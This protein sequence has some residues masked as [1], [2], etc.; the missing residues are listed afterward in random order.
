MLD[1]VSFTAKP[2]QT[3]AILGATGSGK[4]SLVQ[5]L[6][7]L[8]VRTAGSIT[9]AGTDVN[10]IEHGH[11]RQN[12]GIVLQ[13]PFLYSRTI[14][15]NIR[16]C[17]PCSTEED[18]YFAA[19]TAS[20]HEVIENFEQGYDTLVGERGVTLSGGQQQRVAIARTLMQNAPIL[21]FDDSMSAVDSETDAAI[22]RSLLALNQDGITFLISHRI[23]TL[24]E[25]DK[26]L[27]LED[28]RITQ[29]GTHGELIRQE[30]LYRRI[31]EIQ[32][33]ISQEGI[34][35]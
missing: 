6:Q 3:I 14:M 10:D 34:A 21:I 23:T 30:G 9:I 25:A 7:R 33:A 26:I 15:A 35:E 11:L 2:G 29:Q 31:A 22:R 24:R 16:I 12:I 17:A 20:V 18:V 28:G 5:L 1:G 4:T 13:E 32:D 19:R 8:Y 27:V